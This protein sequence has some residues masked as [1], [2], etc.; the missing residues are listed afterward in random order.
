M[1]CWP[2]AR[3]DDRRADAAPIGSIVP[4]ATLAGMPSVMFDAVF[5]CGGDGDGAPRAHADA[6][7]SCAKRS[8]T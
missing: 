8:S 7:I 2:R 3:A 1:R 5:V 4:Q 6:R